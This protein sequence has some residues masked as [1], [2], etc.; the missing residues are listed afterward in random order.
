[1]KNAIAILLISLAC[2]AVALRPTHTCASV[3]EGETVVL[4]HGLVRSSRAMAKL[5]REL[6][7]EGYTVINHDYPSTSA[8]IEVLTNDIFTALAPRISKA[9]TVHF[10]THSMGG[11]ILREHLE[12]HDLPNL[13]R[14]VMLA[15][16]SRGSEVPDKLGRLKPF[17]W[18]N[19]PAGNQLGTGANSHPLRLKEPKFELGIIAGDRSINPILSLLIPGPDDG[20]VS[21]ARV[22]PQTFTDY[23]QLHATH[24]CIGRNRKAIEQTKYFLEHGHFKGDRA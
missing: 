23:T 20:K 15:P 12:H 1:M 24:P 2:L 17:R 5:E 18:I 22:K 6:V 8:S 11:I 19:G 21:L 4:L 13:G 14:V 7:A 3:R 9:Q 10:V 16:P